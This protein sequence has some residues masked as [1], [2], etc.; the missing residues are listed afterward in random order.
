L[1]PPKAANERAADADEAE[2]IDVDAPGEVIDVD[3][4]AAEIID[5]DASAQGDSASLSSFSRFSDGTVSAPIHQLLKRQSQC[6]GQHA[7]PQ[8]QQSLPQML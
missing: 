3:N 5:V 4:D 2:V 1:L 8:I 7:I 6:L